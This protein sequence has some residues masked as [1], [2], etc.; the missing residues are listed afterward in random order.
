MC[1]HRDRFICRPSDTH[2][3]VAARPGRHAGHRAGVLLLHFPADRRAAPAADRP[4]RP[5]PARLPAA[6]AHPGRPQLSSALAMRDMLDPDE[7]YPVAAW[8]S[9]F[10]RIRVDLDDALR[11]QEGVAVA[12][13][14]PEQRSTSASAV[15]QFWDAADAH[16]RARAATGTKTRHAAQIRLS[17]QA[18][19]AALST[20]VARLLV[21]NNESE[22]QTARAGAG[23]ST[24]RCSGRSTGFSPRPWWPS[25]HQPVPDPIEP[26]PVRCSS[27]R[28]RTSGASSR[29][30]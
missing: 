20:A 17:L 30:S 13:R 7:T 10:D 3:C 21:Q 9:Q 29:S 12:R 5:Q 8:S 1:R 4:D 27:R 11:Q 25:R 19:Q 2:S 16:L 26:A 6:A 22:E 23:R 28:C 15:A 24:P 18:R 14:T